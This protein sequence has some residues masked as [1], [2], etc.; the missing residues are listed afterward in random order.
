MLRVILVLA[1]GLLPAPAVAQGGDLALLLANDR[2]ENQRRGNGAAA[3]LDALPRLEAAGFEADLATDLAAA[4]MRAAL[5][6][7]DGRIG[8]ENPERVIIVFAG[9]T[10]HGDQGAWLMGVEAGN[11]N[12][13]SVDAVGLRLDALLA[14][15]G[16][17]QGG[18]IVAIGDLSYPSRPGPGLQPGLG[19]VSV[20]QGVSL[21]RGA[22]DQVARVLERLMVPGTNLRAAVAAGRNVRL[23]GFDPPWLSFLP[24]GHAPVENAD[25]R[26]WAEAREAG[27]VEGFRAYLAAFP[28][29]LFADQARAEI[30]ALET[31]PER[32]EEALG[33]T[34]DER[35]AVQRHL[36]LL[37]F[38]PRGID[39]IFGPGSR[40]AITAWQTREGYE[41]TGFMDRDQVF[42]LAAQAARRAAEIEE[43]ERARQAEQ[44]RRDRAWWRDTG[45]GQDETGL[46][47]YLD[48]YPQGIFSSLARERLADIAAERESARAAQDRAD[49]EAA[50]AADTPDAWRAYLDAWP[51]GDFAS[52]ARQRLAA[53]ERPPGPAPDDAVIIDAE[54]AEIEA[55]LALPRLTRLLVEQRLAMMGYPPGRVDGDFDRDT[56]R[57]IA[58]FQREYG[59]PETGFLSEDS[60][61]LLI[62]GGFRRLLD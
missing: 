21:I 41:A 19:P 24:D 46:R 26:A 10:L 1:F 59:L 54:P 29:G 38:D 40:R 30:T 5:A 50:R 32:I 36:A 28:Q 8:S 48:R 11:E 53:L 17:V 12:L 6:A 23:D 3:V 14:V 33:L 9:H 44:E 62:P 57:A 49:W 52:A 34:R 61:E 47:A 4:P 7:L 55:A 37:G 51:E 13:L 25:R 58:R 43:E 42:R 20:P 15:A 35:R 16:R 39:G 22:P 60:L 45:A 56:R 31:T 27:S 2:Y 18:A